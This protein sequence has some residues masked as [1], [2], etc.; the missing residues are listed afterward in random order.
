MSD[1]MWS[2]DDIADYYSASRTIAKKIVAQP[3]FPAP[4]RLWANAHPRWI[5][6]QVREWIEA[7]QEAA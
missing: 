1:K 3:G 7:Q 5:E 2:L 4:V 6:R